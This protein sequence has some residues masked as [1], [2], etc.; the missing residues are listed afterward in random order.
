MNPTLPLI[1]W[2][3]LKFKQKDKNIS[4]MIKI[5]FLGIL[6]GTF[7][8]MLTLIITNG[9]EKTVCDKMQGINAPIV[10]QSAKNKLNVEKI[11][12]YLKNKYAGQIK[13][14]SGSSRRQLILQDSAK[15]KKNAEQV[16]VCVKGIEPKYESEVTNI[17]SKVTKSFPGIKNNLSKLLN[18]NQILI[19]YKTAKEL[20][21]SVGDSITL[22]IP[23]GGSSKKIFLTKRKALIGGIFKVG[24]DEYDSGFVF[25]SID[26]L[27]KLFDEEGVDQISLKL[28]EKEAFKF[29]F[30]F[31]TKF[32]KD[33]FNRFFSKKNTLTSFVTKL[34]KQFPTFAIFTWQE[35]YPA[36]VSSLKLEKYV[37]FFI[38]ALI[39]LVASM[40]MIS[41][42]FILI[43]QKKRDIAIFK[44]MGMATTKIRNIFLFIGLSITFFAT[45]LG[46]FFAW[47][48]GY[49]LEKYP[50]IQL[51]DVYY[52]SHLPARMEAEIFIVVFVCVI[53]LGFIATWIPAQRAKN[54]HIT[55]VLRME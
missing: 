40:N 14:V 5:C 24:L 51:P 36:I 19:G 54:I 37:M 48:A 4:L 42:L 7:S 8:L 15:S 22:L 44:S 28:E 9:F 12:P 6:I 20:N 31:T 55:Q 39:T 11:R 33:L 27:N 30:L 16:L 35:L 53:L 47:I 21:V 23:E 17:T 18:K 41:L 38:L 29:K 3:Y 50:F 26:F 13:Q 45:T 10:M 25:C 32:Y 43:Q 34:K 46:L 2:R 49:L 52:V 1:V